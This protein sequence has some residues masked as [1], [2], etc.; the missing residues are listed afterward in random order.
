[1]GGL[2]AVGFLV[3]LFALARAADIKHDRSTNAE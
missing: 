2:F 1:M 3:L